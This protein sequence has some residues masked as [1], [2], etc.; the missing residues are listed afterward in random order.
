MVSNIESNY[1][2]SF[3]FSIMLLITIE[4]EAGNEMYD[5]MKRFVRK[6]QMAWSEFERFSHF[7]LYTPFLRKKNARYLYSKVFISELSSHSVLY[8]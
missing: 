8:Y 7:V 5:E 3:Q 6:N 1:S 2:D 4:N